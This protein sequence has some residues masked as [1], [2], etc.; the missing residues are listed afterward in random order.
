VDRVDPAG[1]P[2]QRDW[3]GRDGELVEVLTLLA[4]KADVDLASTEIQSGVQH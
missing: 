4:E 3:V 2:P 1:E